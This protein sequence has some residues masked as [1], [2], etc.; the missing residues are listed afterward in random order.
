[1]R[2]STTPLKPRVFQGPNGYSRKG[3]EPGAA[4]HYYSYTRLYTAG[5]L[6]FG[7]LECGV[8][9]TSW[10]DHEFSSSQLLPDQV[11]WDWFGLQLDD[12]RE[13]MVYLMRHADGSSDYRFA[14]LIDPAGVVTHLEPD[15]WS[16]RSTAVWTSERTGA[17]YPAEWVIEIPG[18]GLDLRIVPLLSDQENRGRVKGAPYYYEG[19][20]EVRGRDGA[21]VGQGYVELTGY[22][23]DN[24]PPV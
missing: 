18:E 23:D 16:A 5:R 10:M 4:S 19:A 15:A 7:E 11:G 21:T 20:V 13:V 24:R 12:G 1:M 14:N 3:D 6:R 9:G 8:D 2:L 22:G 17:V